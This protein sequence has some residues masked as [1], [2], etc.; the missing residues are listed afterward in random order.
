MREAE[1]LH[2]TRCQ[3]LRYYGGKQR[4]GKAKWIAGLLPWGKESSYCEPFGGMASVLVTRAVVKNE[5]YND[6]DGRIVNW[7]EMLRMHTDRFCHD[8]EMMPVSRAEFEGAHRTLADPSASDYERALAVQVILGQSIIASL[9]YFAWG[10]D[11]A[12]RRGRTVWSSERVRGLAERIRRVQLECRPAIE[13]LHWLQDSD[14]TVIYCDPPYFSADCRKYKH[15]EVDVGAMGEALQAQAGQVAISGYGSEW[16][17]LGW[18][19]HEKPVPFSGFGKE[20]AKGA[21]RRV[22]VLWT[23]YDALAEG[24]AHA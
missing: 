7:W 24:A 20:V 21:Q 4:N 5:T 15:Q 19:R 11:K 12:P 1:Y 18:Q 13:I 16:D 6:L 14:Y 10:K 3:P 23:N 9:N 2:H 22:E 17:N 8:V